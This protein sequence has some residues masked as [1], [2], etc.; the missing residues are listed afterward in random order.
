M[1]Y[2][3]I[4]KL[5]KIIDSKYS[6]VSVA[7][8]RARNLQEDGKETLDHFASQKYVGKALEEIYAKTLVM[9]TNADKEQA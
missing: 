3:S 6:L 7:A 4:D 9:K 2:P 8:K 1:L 5:L